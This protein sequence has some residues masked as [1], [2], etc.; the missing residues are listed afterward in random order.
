[1]SS[2]GIII[3]AKIEEVEL[4]PK[5]QLVYNELDGVTAPFG[6]L[7]Y[8][9]ERTVNFA[10]TVKQI[11]RVSSK[12]SSN[13]HMLIALEARCKMSFLVVENL[14]TDSN[15]LEV[16]VTHDRKLILNQY[17]KG[18]YGNDYIHY[19]WTIDLLN[20]NAFPFIEEIAAYITAVVPNTRAYINPFTNVRNNDLL[21]S[22][23][24][25]FTNTINSAYGSV[26]N[27]TFY[28]DKGIV[29][30]SISISPG[31]LPS[32]TVFT[33]KASSSDVVD[34]FDYHVDYWTGKITTGE[35]WG[36]QEVLFGYK[37]VKPVT[38]IPAMAGC[39]LT[40]L[41]DPEI[42]ARLIHWSDPKNTIP[43]QDRATVTD[44]LGRHIGYGG[45][46]PQLSKTLE[47]AGQISKGT[48]WG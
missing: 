16:K 8:A 29:P 43:N 47:D 17:S 25:V 18:A 39:S 46:S 9:N 13:L 31:A 30:E 19:P 45:V 12:D 4:V 26:T 38:Y 11:G 35:K 1:M 42:A 15:V 3:P 40:T 22:H 41:C 10:Q 44:N 21:P 5:A 6:A 14:D 20:R 27:N 37:R 24:P 23:L 33:K 48:R 2:I 7:R 36:R 34:K 28:A 32:D